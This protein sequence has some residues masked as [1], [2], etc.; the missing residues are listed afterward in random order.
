MIQT[1]TD[2]HVVLWPPPWSRDSLLRKVAGLGWAVAIA[3]VIALTSL[4]VLISLPLQRLAAK[5]AGARMSRIE[6][7]TLLESFADGTAGPWNWDD[8]LSVPIGD[9]YLDRIRLRCSKL[10]KEFPPDVPGQYCGARGL[11]VLRDFVAELRR[12]DV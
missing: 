8:F 12:A 5:R 7:A 10:D 4:V 2:W 9:P 11:A 3:P 1:L 6:M